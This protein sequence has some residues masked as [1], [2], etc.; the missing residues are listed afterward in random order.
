M[1]T[2]RIQIPRTL[3]AL[4]K[5]EPLLGNDPTQPGTQACRAVTFGPFHRYSV[6][7]V[8]CRDYNGFP[9]SRLSW[10]VYDAEVIDELGYPAVI[11]QA[12]TLDEALAGLE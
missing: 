9:P 6:A 11:R 5:L 3:A 10:F 2:P 7:P 8:N 4:R 1:K 12:A